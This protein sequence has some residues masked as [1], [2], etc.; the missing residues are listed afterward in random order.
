MVSTTENISQFYELYDD[1]YAGFW[2]HHQRKDF[3][4]KI[5]G[6]ASMTQTILWMQNLLFI[7]K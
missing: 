4:M 5:S 3:P 7:E 1:F 2:N 6:L